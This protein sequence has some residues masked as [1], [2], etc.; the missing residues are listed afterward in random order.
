M[1]QTKDVLKTSPSDNINLDL[2]LEIRGK[3][4]TGG[5]WFQ[6][7]PAPTIGNHYL[8]IHNTQYAYTPELAMAAAA[9]MY[10]DFDCV[11]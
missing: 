2:R 11:P 7:S 3:I 6:P 1:I 9:T 5:F 8:H 4:L 10:K